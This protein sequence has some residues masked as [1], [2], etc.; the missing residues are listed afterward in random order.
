MSQELN[1]NKSV[2]SDMIGD[3][4]TFWFWVYVQCIYIFFF[5]WDGKIMTESMT[6]FFF[7]SSCATKISW[8]APA[9]PTLEVSSFQFVGTLEFVS[10]FKRIFV[11]LVNNSKKKKQS[12]CHAVVPLWMRCLISLPVAMAQERWALSWMKSS[13]ARLSHSCSSHSLA[14]IMFC[15]KTAYFVT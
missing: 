13:E 4:K 11:E 1:T 12:Q 9:F 3:W 8:F 5:A 6:Y 2:F 14:T 15:K 7:L 10:S